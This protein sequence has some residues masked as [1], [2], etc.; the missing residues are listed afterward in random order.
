MTQLH[1]TDIDGVRCFWVDSGRPTLVA[2]LM[3]RHGMADETFTE[4]GWAHAIEHLALHGRGSGS[5]SVNGSVSPLITSFDSHGPSSAV[6]SHLADVCAWLANPTFELLDRERGV[7]RAESA[8]RDNPAS[9]ALTWRFGACGAGLPG[10]G[11]PGLWRATPEGLAARTARVFNRA[12]AILVLDGAPPV[13]LVLP[14]PSGDFQPPRETIPCDQPLPAAYQE[15]SGVVISGLVPRSSAATVLPALL[16]RAFTDTFRVQAGSAYAPWG[17]YEAVGGTDAVV[18]AGTDINPDAGPSVARLTL[19]LVSRLSREGPDPEQLNELVEAI[20]QSVSDPYH[21]AALAF[22]AAHAAFEGRA[23]ETF[24]EVLDGARSLTP[25]TVG[26]SLASFCSSL[27]LGLPPGAAWYDE[28][29]T[30]RQ[31]TARVGTGRRFRHRN[32]P[33]TAA[34]VV[35]GQDQ[36]Q[37]GAGELLTSMSLG[38]VVGMHA[39]PDGRR[40]LTC[41]D[42][43]TIH[44]DPAEWHGGR[45]AVALL[46]DLVPPELH[47]ASPTHEWP[48]S[49]P[50]MAWR[51]RWWIGF[52]T[53]GTTPRSALWLLIGLLALDAVLAAA[54]RSLYALVLFFVTG[55]AILIQVARV[56]PKDGAE[57]RD[58]G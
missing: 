38:R 55:V 34:R 23:P 7:L 48:S 40:G 18:I 36:I 19:D 8:L 28:L 16:Q 49:T 31:P 5:L 45:S 32:W 24:E 54:T 21:V 47:I 35:I 14:L 57:K 13:D 9:R 33:G 44:V 2:S 58:A 52:S 25:E 37:V 51:R 22:R 4:S 46:D 3:F 56:L 27:L 15:R 12:N 10:L 42:G 26:E 1:D 39:S 17:H 41:R 30:L 20:V 6:R 43:W 53:F 11:E 29:P 50:R